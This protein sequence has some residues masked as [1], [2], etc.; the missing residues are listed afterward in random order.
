MP[1]QSD[2]AT[3][4][5]TVPPDVKAALVQRAESEDRTEGSVVKRAL[6]LYLSMP[7]EE[8]EQRLRELGTPT[9]EP[10]TE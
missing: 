9:V 6:R 4:N 8:T 3:V 7:V 10:P 1:R 2:R 5:A